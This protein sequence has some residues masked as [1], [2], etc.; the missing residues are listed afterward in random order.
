[1]TARPKRYMTEEEYTEFEVASP[2]K[3]EYYQGDI[4]AM[5]GGTEPHNCA[6]DPSKD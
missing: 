6:L 4:F 5:T 2:R 3:H 1:M